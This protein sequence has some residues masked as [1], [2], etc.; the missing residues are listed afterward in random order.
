MAPPS[1]TRPPAGA[2]Q[3]AQ[4]AGRLARN[5]AFFC[6]AV[7]LGLGCDMGPWKAVPSSVFMGPHQRRAHSRLECRR[8]TAHAGHLWRGIIADNSDAAKR[9]GRVDLLPAFS[10]AALLLVVPPAEMRLPAFLCW[11]LAHPATIVSRQTGE[12][13]MC[14]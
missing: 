6:A 9:G 5:G 4:R 11:C 3:R 1:A 8:Q 12:Q 13:G 10:G 2:G 7:G 14:R